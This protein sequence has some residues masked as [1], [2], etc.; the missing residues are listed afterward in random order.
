MFEIAEVGSQ[1]SKEEYE[2]Q[3]PHLRVDL[4]NVQYDLRNAD[5]PTLLLIVGDD[6][7]GCNEI[8][9]LLHEWMDARYLDTHVFGSLTEEE[10]EHP[11]FWRYWRT[12]PRKGQLSVYVGAWARS[13]VVDRAREKISDREFERR[14]AHIARF[15]QALVD[16]G[17]L[18]LKFWLHLPKKALKR[19]LKKNNKGWR[20]DEEGTQI[21]ELYDEV[22]PLGERLIRKTSTGS[23]RWHI[24]ETTDACY[25]NVT[26]ARVLLDSLTARLATHKTAKPKRA[27]RTVRR[28]LVP[29]VGVN[30]L[31]TLDLTAELPWKEY[32]QTLDKLQDDLQLLSQR[33]R[34]KGVS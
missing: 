22:L 30:V 6:H 15:E 29:E 28:D 12:L 9:N 27:E 5:F 8:L 4:I 2:A 33:A 10:Q 21:Y 19:R 13:A 17:A 1:V 32:K 23:A 14:T 34:E 20:G 26:V 31:E 16:D 7:H 11:R 25:R 24:V 3:V 18:V